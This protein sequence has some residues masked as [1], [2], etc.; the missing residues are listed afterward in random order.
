MPSITS[1]TVLLNDKMQ[2]I[3]SEYMDLNEFIF[4]VIVL[5]KRP[6]KELSKLQRYE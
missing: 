6:I 3:L 1:P 5:R 2:F 4:I